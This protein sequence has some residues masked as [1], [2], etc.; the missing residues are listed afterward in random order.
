MPSAE[1]RQPVCFKYKLTNTRSPTKSHHLFGEQVDT[2]GI[3]VLFK[4]DSALLFASNET[5]YR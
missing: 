1:M 4:L 3:R 2:N 5:P